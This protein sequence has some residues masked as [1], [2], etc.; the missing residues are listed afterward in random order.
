MYMMTIQIQVLIET[1]IRHGKSE[2]AGVKLKTFRPPLVYLVVR[3][4]NVSSEF[5][6]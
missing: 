6:N 1:M 4:G 5:L 2:I 3:K